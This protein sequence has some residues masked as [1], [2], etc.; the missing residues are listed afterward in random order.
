MF[1]SSSKL[2]LLP[3]DHDG[4]I[5]ADCAHKQGQSS[6]HM[7]WTCGAVPPLYVRPARVHPISGE[8][9]VEEV[10]HVPCRNLNFQGDCAEFERKKPELPAVMVES[11]TWAAQG[12]PYRSGVV[13]PKPVKRP[14]QTVREKIGHWLLRVAQRLLKATEA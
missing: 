12:D 8:V 5:C 6:E 2:K 4:P 10:S 14:S 3:A 13:F 9:E 7:W 11:S 1:D